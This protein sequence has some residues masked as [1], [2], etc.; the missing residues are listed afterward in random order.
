MEYLR[1]AIYT[2]SVLSVLILVHEW[3]HFIVAKLCGMHVKDFSLFFGKR[4]IRLGERN[5]TEYNIRM[6]PLGGFVSIVGMEPEDISN[7]APIFPKKSDTQKRFHKV[8]AG[9]TTEVL[10]SINFDYVSERVGQAA[11]D[12]VDANGDLSEN[13]RRELNSLLVSSGL[14][15]DEHQYLEAILN[16]Q[17]LPP[18]PNGYNQKPLWQRAA[19]IFAGPFMSIAFGYLLFCGMG[20]TTGLPYD[21]QLENVVEVVM[22]GYARFPRRFA[23][24]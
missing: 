1:S 23:C 10:E 18:D 11:N 14:T 16:A 4:L 8:M 3:G 20:L 24:R 5:G 6:I 9:L 15:V 13:G 17:A 7:G 12:A 22:K 21:D 19:T 2:I